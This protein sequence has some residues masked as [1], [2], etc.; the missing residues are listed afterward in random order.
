M[1]SC[2]ATAT[3]RQSNFTLYEYSTLFFIIVAAT[4]K[5]TTMRL[6]LSVD[7]ATLSSKYMKKSC[8]GLVLNFLDRLFKSKQS[9]FDVT[10]KGQIL[11]RIR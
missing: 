6:R 4:I 7:C 10:P 11:A 3:M 8:D 5:F 1:K 9:F 2:S